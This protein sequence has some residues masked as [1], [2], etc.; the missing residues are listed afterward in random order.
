MERLSYGSHSSSSLQKTSVNPKSFTSH[1]TIPSDEIIE[2][3]YKKIA[4]KNG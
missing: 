4:V 2:E 1:T 3:F